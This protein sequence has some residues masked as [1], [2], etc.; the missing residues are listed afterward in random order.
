MAYATGL[1]CTPPYG[2]RFALAW[3]K[4]HCAASG[5]SPE[6]VIRKPSYLLPHT[7]SWPVPHQKSGISD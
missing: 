6:A 7:D 2:L 4:I 5:S 3:Q 1:L